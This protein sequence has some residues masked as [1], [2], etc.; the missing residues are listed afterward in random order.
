MQLFR[1]AIGDV[2]RSEDL[3]V[4]RE[5]PGDNVIGARTVALPDRLL[6]VL[7]VDR[8]LEQAFSPAARDPLAR[9]DAPPRRLPGEPS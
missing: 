9:R 1:D 4:S 6:T 3:Q 7:E 8:V 5:H 2:R